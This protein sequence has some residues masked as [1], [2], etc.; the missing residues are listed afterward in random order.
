MTERVGVALNQIA[1]LM[2]ESKSAT[3]ELKWN[4]PRQRTATGLASVLN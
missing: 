1:F 4:Q 3:V 2:Y